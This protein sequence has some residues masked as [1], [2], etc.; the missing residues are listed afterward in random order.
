[1]DPKFHKQVNDRI[2]GGDEVEPYSV[3]FQVSF[4]TS[5]GSHV[6]GGSVLSKVRFI[7]ITTGGTLAL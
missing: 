6:C 1:M 3:P 2:I 7:V 5:D 4:Q